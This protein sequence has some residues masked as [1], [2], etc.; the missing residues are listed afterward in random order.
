MHQRKSLLH[1][2]TLFSATKLSCLLLLLLFFN[3][4]SK[5]EGDV[6]PPVVEVEV[7]LKIKDYALDKGVWFGMAYDISSDSTNRAIFESEVNAGQVGWY[8]A[9]GGWNGRDL[10]DFSELNEEINYVDAQGHPIMMH[11][12]F[13]PDTYLPDWF[14]DGNW[15]Q[16]EM[17]TMMHD[18]VRNVFQAN[19]NGSKVEVWNVVNEAISWD[20]DEWESSKWLEMGFE[21]DAS[22][23]TGTDKVFDSIPV[24]VTKAFEFA[25]LYTNKGL[26]LRDYL[27]DGLES[28]W[29]NSELR[30][31]SFYQLA[32]HLVNSGAPINA[33]GF[34]GHLNIDVPATF[35]RLTTT[36]ERYKAL[37]LKVYITELDAEQND[38]STLWNSSIA[39]AQAEYYYNYVKAALDGGVDGIFTWGIRDNQDPWW[40]FDENPL[41][42]DAE[43]N[44]K[45]AYFSVK[46]AFIDS[47]L[48]D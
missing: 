41:L 40:R 26:E 23:L 46:Q 22:G 5:T 1:Y 13:G 38:Q 15:S 6:E 48:P 19:D 34:Q 42:F 12:L 11:M 8:P 29:N 10:Y 30:T 4:C 25:G 36:V 16:E 47:L 39:S 3:A 31:K 44:A 2:R 24:Y 37:G 35:S 9:W 21:A 27:N 17:E 7:P 33:V 32:L 43:G 45:P 14:K 18:L 20:G 28:R